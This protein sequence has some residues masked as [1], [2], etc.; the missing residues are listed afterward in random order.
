M[1]NTLQPM[2]ANDLPMEKTLC[3]FQFHKEN[4]KTNKLNSQRRQKKNE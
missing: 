2:S 1:K 4:F 3:V